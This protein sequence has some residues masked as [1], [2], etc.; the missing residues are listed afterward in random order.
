MAR[1]D[2]DASAKPSCVVADDSVPKCRICGEQF[3]KFWDE[4][5]E[6]WMYKN[7]VHGKIHSTSNSTASESIFHQHCYAAATSESKILSAAQL[8]PGTPN[9][10]NLRS[11]SWSRA[12]QTAKR[13]LGESLDPNASKKSKID[14]SIHS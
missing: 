14:D 4:D 6:E 5:E 11:G 1:L 9:S 7:T 13:N 10:P 12:G 3:V 2:D 8:A